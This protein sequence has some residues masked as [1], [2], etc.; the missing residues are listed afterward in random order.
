MDIIYH[1]HKAE[2]SDHMRQRAAAGI[3]KLT[4]RMEKT[5]DAI[6]RFEQDGP[7][8]RVEIILQAPRQRKLVAEAEGRFFGPTLVVALGRLKRQIGKA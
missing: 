1:S 3:R 6:V 2:I 7:T 5:V 4:A 8:R